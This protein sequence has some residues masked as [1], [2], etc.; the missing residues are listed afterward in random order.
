MRGKTFPKRKINPDPKYNRSDIAKFINYIMRRG[1]K[2]TAQRIIYTAFDI[3]EKQAN[4]DPFEIY[5]KALK[6]V[7]P[8]LEVRGRRIGG[9]NYQIPFPVNE[10]RRLTLSLRWIINAAKA[11]KGK[12]MHQALA[13][14]LMDAAKGE[15]AAFKKKED[16]HKMAE[17]NRAFAHFARFSKRKK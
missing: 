3:I 6:N 10:D 12:N 2:S 13:E 11:R 9:A 1:K 16:T 4:T 14:E 15:G 17:S 8:S 7:G 5:E